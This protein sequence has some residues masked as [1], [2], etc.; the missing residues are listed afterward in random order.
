MS[1]GAQK[2]AEL[3]RGSAHLGP[4][5]RASV[6]RLVERLMPFRDSSGEFSS[7]TAKTGAPDAGF[8]ISRRFATFHNDLLRHPKSLRRTASQPLCS[9]HSHSSCPRHGALE[10]S[11]GCQCLISGSSA[12]VCSPLGN[13]TTP[14]GLF[15]ALTKHF[16]FIR[17]H[18]QRLCENG[19]RRPRSESSP[20]AY[21]Q[22]SR[23]RN[24]RRRNGRY[25]QRLIRA[26]LRLR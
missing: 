6:V 4:P 10:N 9:R 18:S 14:G 19:A 8:P 2:W 23:S 26:V 12:V 13:V 11:D 20:I 3:G 17:R 25:S 21:G 24:S 22:W 15:V 7:A 5:I 16:L 1:T